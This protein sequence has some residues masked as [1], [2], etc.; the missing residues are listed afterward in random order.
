[1]GNGLEQ[2]SRI[3]GSVLGH[4]GSYEVARIQ[5]QG[6]CWIIMFRDVVGHVAWAERQVSGIFVFIL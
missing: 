3:G 4:G 2:T 1:M 6:T 5:L